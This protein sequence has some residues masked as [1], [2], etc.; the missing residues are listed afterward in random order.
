MPL[1]G[2][3]DNVRI[4][5]SGK[6]GTVN[7]V[8]SRHNTFGYRVTVD[9]NVTTYQEKYLEHIVDTR[10][11]IKTSVSMEEFYGFD[12]F[13]LFQ[14]WYRLKRPLEGNYY[15]YLGSK[16]IFNPYQFKPLAKFIA[17]G[18]E[19]RLFIADEVGV[20]KTIETGIILMELAAR[21]RI[22]RRS[23]VLIVC[24]NSL[25]TKWIREMRDRFNFN[26]HLHDGPSLNNMLNC[27]LDGYIPEN[28]FWSVASIQLLRME[29]YLN[30]LVEI[31]GMRQDPL[32]NFVVIDE[33]HHMRN[34]STESNALGSL[35]SDMTEMML[36]LSATPLNLRDED[37]F[38]QM[39]ILNKTVFTD[40]QTFNTMLFPVKLL[41]KGRSLLAQRTNTVYGELL[42]QLEELRSGPLGSAMADHP[43]LNTL[44]EKVKAG[45]SLTTSEIAHYDR[46]LSDLSPLSHSFTRTLKKEAMGQRITREV[47]KVP[48][49]LTPPE[50]DFYQSVIELT[51]DAYLEGG[52]NPSALGFVTNM[53]R[54]MVTSC[55]PAMYD[56]LGWCLEKNQMLIDELE[57]SEEVEDDSELET[58]PLSP[59]L[60]NNYVTLRKQ[61]Q[62][63]AG[64]DTKYAAFVKI[65]R[66]MQHTLDNPQIIVF[67]FFVRTLKYLQDKLTSE[68]FSIGLI[69][70]EI[71]TVSD[72]A[73]QGRDDIIE[74]FERKE[75]DILLSSEVGG[76]GLDFQF[77][78]A[79]VNY[80]LPYNPMRVEQRIGRI[81]RF[82]Q[83]TDKV[84]IASMY[85]K[86]TLDEKIYAA[87]Y[88]RIKIV[89]NSV[90]ELEPI[91]GSKLLDLQKDIISGQLTTEQFNNRM[92]EIEAAVVN[93]KLEM[94]KFEENRQ[95]LMGEEDFVS[96][97]QNLEHTDFVKPADASHLTSILINA[98]P[99]CSYQANS[100]ETGILT[101]SAEAVA[102]IEQFTR[103][104]GAEGSSRELRPLIN[105]SKP[106]PVFFN[107]SVFNEH[108]DH[109][110]LPPCGFWTRFL[111]KELETEGQINHTFSLWTSNR[112]I[113]LENGYYIVPLFEIIIEGF[114]E[115]IDLAAVPIDI[116]DLTVVP[117]DYSKM[118]RLLTGEMADGKTIPPGIDDPEMLENVLHI[119]EEA[120]D[121][122]MEEKLARLIAENNY[123][124]TSRISSLQK[125]SEMRLEK[126]SES[127]AMHQKRA[128]AE[129]RAP[130]PDYI[131]LTEA[132][133]HNEEKRTKTKI[134][135]LAM[136]KDL[137]KGLVLIA[138]VLLEVEKNGGL[139][140]V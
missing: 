103:L 87:L 24:P 91:L 66:D 60:R 23:P 57:T 111:L 49:T 108:R 120:L 52:G 11:E 36:M 59:E 17:P 65:I 21:G 12:H 1:F 83:Q 97:I 132:R 51:A 136:K 98:W 16:T 125:G 129:N 76:E 139:N 30:V 105:A 90:G 133:I 27:V 31:D 77:C 114:R 69:C 135:N 127:L 35:L 82:G 99:G 39:H 130:N 45:N 7:E 67:S 28:N 37:L 71:P 117:C 126:M 131:R 96:K 15:S 79:I 54:R 74:A 3:G 89:E 55:I 50:M 13:R 38:N 119:A 113:P 33:A 46:V 106:H 8:L 116:K 73:K 78:Q 20:G 80:D 63:L 81:D 56:Y 84:I 58:T 122:N 48:V 19:E 62:K 123:R 72:G 140:Y 94:A 61:A 41:N 100:P 18:S 44:Y 40:K 109:T 34:I 10:S 14:T 93:A 112:E 64:T 2:K 102:K 104:P 121:Q 95:S 32:W 4:I 43:D 137:S 70:G 42:N 22:D 88:D 5:S 26:F 85:I 47:H 68:G 107:G 53:P 134:S 86:H 6:I 115:E 124:I 138:I 110:F 9:G 128:L 29:K 118:S 101:L 75:F 92:N 25:A